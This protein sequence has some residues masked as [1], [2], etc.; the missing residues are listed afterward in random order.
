VWRLRRR[1]FRF[2]C[3]FCGGAFFWVKV[4][5]VRRPNSVPVITALRGDL[6]CGECGLVTGYD[7][8]VKQQRGWL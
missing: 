2:L 7:D 5:L 6:E 1:P 8:F 3:P 4:A